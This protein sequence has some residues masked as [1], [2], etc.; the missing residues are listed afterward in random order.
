M[1][2]RIQ[3]E[4]QRATWGLEARMTADLVTLEVSFA[5]FEIKMDFLRFSRCLFGRVQAPPWLKASRNEATGTISTLLDVEFVT[6][7]PAKTRQILY[8][9]TKSSQLYSRKF[10]WT[11]A[12][13]WKYNAVRLQIAKLVGSLAHG[14]H[15]MASTQWKQPERKCR[16]MSA[17]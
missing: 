16:Y 10:I 11:A 12:R 4:T 7:K 13:K 9:Y 3:Y 8:H 15:P 17:Y 2:A 5:I 6:I 1:P 14:F